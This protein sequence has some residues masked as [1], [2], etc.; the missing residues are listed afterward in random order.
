M[1][2]DP[3]AEAIAASRPPDRVK[4]GPDVMWIGPGK[5]PW[6]RR[7]WFRTPRYE[8]WDASDGRLVGRKTWL[9]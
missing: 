8:Y 4:V 5:Y 3:E 2:R 9:N 6:E 7:I 1:A